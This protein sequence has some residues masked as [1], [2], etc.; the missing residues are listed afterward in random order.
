[1]NIRKAEPA[2][3]PAIIAL[4]QRSMVGST[5]PKSEKYWR[6]KHQDNPF[7]PSPVLL[8][9]AD[10]QL[11]GVRAF[12]RW[13]WNDNGYSRKALRAVDTA[14][15]PDYR[16]QGI[17][18][19]LTLRL[20][21]D[22]QREGDDFI[23]NTPNEKSAPGYLKMGWEKMGKIP[24]NLRIINPFNLAVNVAR[25]RPG[26]APPPAIRRGTADLAV[27]N[28]LNFKQQGWYTALTAD[29]LQWRYATCPVVDYSA[30]GLTERFLI[31]YYFKDQQWGREM[32]IVEKVV[33]S[34]QASACN[35]HIARLARESGA[36][37]ISQA[38]AAGG[39]HWLSATLSV[40]PLLTFRP[41]N[42]ANPPAVDEWHFSLG[43]LEL[44]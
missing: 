13:S 16:G 7:G 41:L 19:T 30:F 20:V 2:D 38:P 4:L 15:D 32:R 44:F 6:W 23:F 28:S 33:A 39:A 29:F 17:F 24:V 8:A 31:V 11:V 10:G 40:G 27:L 18:K 34:G 21:E 5:T 22:C 3:L 42:F 43:D 14:T 36:V 12:M 37:L 25:R 26:I 9:E 35:Q 1:M